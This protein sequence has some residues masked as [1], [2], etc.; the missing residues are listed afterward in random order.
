MPCNSEHM[1]P[2]GIEEDTSK[3]FTL[4]DEIRTGKFIRRHWEG[5][6][7]SVYGNAPVLGSKKLDILTRK[8]CKHLQ[9][10]D[11]KQYSLEMQMWW[12]DHKAADRARVRREV[13]AEKRA[14][15][16]AKLLAKLTPYER[17]LLDD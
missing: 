13:R 16:R 1:N 15:D 9:E 14:K 4:L 12:R 8:L 2:T 7:P 10:N 11:P 5:Y 17:S 3:I 6:H